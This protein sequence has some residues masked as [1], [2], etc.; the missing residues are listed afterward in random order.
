MVKF[1]KG[2]E[3]PWIRYKC[4]KKCAILHFFGGKQQIPRQVANSVAR[5]ENPHVVEYW[6]SWSWLCNPNHHTAM[7]LCEYC[8]VNS[9]CVRGDCVSS[10]Y[11]VYSLL[12]FAGESYCG[13]NNGGCSHICLPSPTFV[14]HSCSCPDNDRVNAYRLNP[15]G[16]TCLTTPC[17]WYVPEV[18]FC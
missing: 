18:F 1:K 10:S 9:E 3:K 4:S 17:Q 2:P 7:Q 15:D 13:D 5:H 14:R 12:L 6:W 8:Y 16:K 11:I